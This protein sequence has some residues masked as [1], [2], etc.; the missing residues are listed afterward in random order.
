MRRRLLGAMAGCVTPAAMMAKG[1]GG[2]ARTGASHFFFC[3]SAGEHTEKGEEDLGVL[4]GAAGLGQGAGA[5][6]RARAL[7]VHW[8]SARARALPAAGLCA[9]IIP[10]GRAIV[11]L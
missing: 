7:V 8:M 4:A 11:G 9:A 1:V 2:A 3:L 5:S 10:A 6:R